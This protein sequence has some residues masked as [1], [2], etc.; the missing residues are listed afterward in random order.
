MDALLW[1]LLAVLV[2][3]TAVAFW[4][5]RSVRSA[6]RVAAL[7]IW[8][9]LQANFS[10]PHEFRPVA[11]GDFPNLAEEG[12]T[13]AAAALEAAGYRA[14]GS[15]EDVTLSSIT[16]AHR[17]RIDCYTHPDGA[18][19]AATYWIEGLQILELC[20]QTQHDRCIATNNA[21]RNRFD[22]PPEVEQEKHP[23]QT[24][25]AQLIGRHAQ[26]IAPHRPRLRPLR[27]LEDA[28]EFSRWLSMLTVEH[29]RKLGYITQA[30]LQAM[31]A[32]AG[33]ENLVG[34]LWREIQAIRGY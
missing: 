8:T 10:R 23:T 29:R 12:Y 9:E 1:I 2:V 34:M 24:D 22:A 6:C 11:R 14:V 3:G 31:A 7:Q 20:S 30:E 4:L 18:T 19:G 5:Q 27:T 17:T 25:F 26:R 21:E 32:E 13:R 33:R 28:L 16:P 15:I